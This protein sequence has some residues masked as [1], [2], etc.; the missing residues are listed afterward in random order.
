MD[1]FGVVVNGAV[2]K[3]WTGPDAQAKALEQ[4]ER[5]TR[6]GALNESWIQGF[7]AQGSNT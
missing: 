5:L 1:T 6:P 7:N 2:W 4:A 3:V